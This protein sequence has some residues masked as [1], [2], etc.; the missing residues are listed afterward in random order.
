MSA[1]ISTLKTNNYGVSRRLGL[2]IHIPFCRS[3]CLYCDFCS[4]TGAELS[5]MEAYIDALCGEIRA[6]SADC[7][8]YLVDT[9]YFG[10]GTPS[11]LPP[12]LIGR[13]IAAIR[14]CF[15]IAPDAEI[16]LECNPMTVEGKARNYFRMLKRLGFNRLSIGVQS[17]VD[18][19]LKLIGRRHSFENVRETYIDGALESWIY[20]INLDLMLGLPSQTL[21]SLE[22]SVRALC[23]LE[24]AHISIYS[25]QLEEGTALYRLRDR[26][27]LPDEELCADMYEL[28]VRLLREQGYEHY[29]ISNFALP[30]GESRHNRKY[31]ALD[32]YLGFGLAAH[33]DIFGQRLENT[34]NLDDY[35][36]G[37]YLL[38][39]RDIGESER[40]FEFIMLGLRTSRGIS[41]KE[42]FGR[43]GIDF[44]EKY[45]EK[46]KNIEK[47]GY[48]AR[49]DEF[50]ALNERGFEVSNEI[51]TEILDFEY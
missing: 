29:E 45:G 39:A 11:V 51:L 15:I 14:E 18:S 16:T 1:D 12:L 23:A 27:E 34:K 28:V 20:N 8:G 36:A 22:Y 44:D 7:S 10:G 40:E 46:V 35:L 25:L 19:E 2:Y 5:D 47:A 50:L 21:E 4:F 49:N 6:R 31:W 17:A 30:G 48:L 32:E 33:S 13:V 37:K 24:P 3:K 41:K 42:F 26:Y 9:V 38:S 43:F